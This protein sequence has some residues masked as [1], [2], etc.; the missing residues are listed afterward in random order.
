MRLKAKN[1]SDLFF[2]DAALGALK[3][4][5]NRP[6]RPV[7]SLAGNKKSDGRYIT[8]HATINGTKKRYYAHRIIWELHNGTIPVG[9]CIDHI[10]G[11]GLNN[12][13][14]NLRAVSLSKNQRNSKLDKRNTTGVHGVT[15]HDRGGFTV[16]CAGKYIKYTSDFFEAC[17][18]RKSAENNNDF[19]KNHGRIA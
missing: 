7:G 3:W 16:S 14:D 19:H 10:D 15:V 4:K 13:I 8:I 11:D 12:K 17:C 5:V 6:K 2:Y 18:A 9:A 1:F